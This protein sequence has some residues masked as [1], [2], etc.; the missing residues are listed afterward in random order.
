[1]VSRV[2]ACVMR[3]LFILYIMCIQ[4]T[5]RLLL[6]TAAPY[7]LAYLRAISIAIANYSNISLV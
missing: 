2:P 1:M 3:I 5:T 4:Y 6:V 7:L